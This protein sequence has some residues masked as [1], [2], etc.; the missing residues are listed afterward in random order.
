MDLHQAGRVHGPGIALQGTVFGVEVIQ[1]QKQ[2]VKIIPAAGTAAKI[3]AKAALA[4]TVAGTASTARAT[5]TGRHRF[6]G[7]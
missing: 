4:A 3:E 1:L 2:A 6:R 5:A 7:S